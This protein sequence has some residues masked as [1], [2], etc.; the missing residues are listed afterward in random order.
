M[1]TKITSKRPR[2]VSSAN[3]LALPLLENGDRLDQKTFHERYEAMPEGVKAELIGGIVY[4]ASPLKKRHGRPHAQV[5]TWL[6]TYEEATPGVESLDNT[7][8]I[9]GD[10]SEPQPD[11][12][13]LILPEYG[14][15]TREDENENMVG[16][17][18]FIAEIASSTES[19]DLHAKRKDYERA[20]VREYM[21][22]AV[23]QRQVFWWTHHKG[24]FKPLASGADGIFRSI[25]FPGLWLDS[26]A[27]LRGDLRRLLAVLRQGLATPDHAAFARELAGRKRAHS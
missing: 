13:L 18:E 19:I 27:L 22:A 23:R 20:G 10:K 24:K 11:G 14:G 9:M 16:S 15:Q 1:S 5:M 8:T 2:A 21:V 12:C 6:G 17:P 25:V 26:K 4:M 7:T 3:G